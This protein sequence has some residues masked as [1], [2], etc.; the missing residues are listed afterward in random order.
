MRFRPCKSGGEVLEANLVF[1]FIMAFKELYPDSFWAVE[2]P[3]ENT[4]TSSHSNHLDALI[5][6]DGTLY[7]IEA[8]RD[9]AT[10]EQLDLIRKDLTRIKSAEL[11]KA[12]RDMWKRDVYDNPL[13]E[14]N[15]VIGVLLADTWQNSNRKAWES[16]SYKG[17]P[18]DWLPAHRAKI[19][20]GIYAQGS[21]TPYTLLVAHTD[22]LTKTLDIIRGNSGE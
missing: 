20:L 12:I 9:Y 19:G 22:N 21:K 13:G 17:E 18:Q 4:S 1:S 6:I 15:E 5:Y 11:A 2:I 8:K 7:L 10:Q 14:V 16:G 3:F